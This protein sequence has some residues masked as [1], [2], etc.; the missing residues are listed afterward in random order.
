MT[1]SE[2]I[3]GEERGWLGLSRSVGGTRTTHP[4]TPS[5]QSRY[6]GRWGG[7]GCVLAI[8]VGLFSVGQAPAV[9]TLL[10]Q[11]PAP[12]LTFDDDAGTLQMFNVFGDNTGFDIIDPTAGKSPFHIDPAALDNSLFIRNTGAVGFGTASPLANIHIS[13]STA[14]PTLR[15]QATTIPGART[16]E[17]GVKAGRF[18]LVDVTGGNATPFAVGAATPTNTLFLSNTGQIGM[19]TAAPDSNSRLDIRSTLT[20]GILLKNSAATG[21][22]LR[23]ENSAAA[24][25]CGVQGNGDAQFGMVT[26]G[27]GLFFTAGNAGRME[28]NASGQISFG[29]TPPTITTDALIHTSGAKL[30]IGGVWTSVSSRAA[31]QDIETITSE[32][33]RD[34]VLALQPVG[35]RYKNELD[36]RYL[37]FIAED[38]PE[39]V[40]TRDR[41]GLAPMDIT[42]VLTKVVQDQDRLLEDQKRVLL[43]QGR[44][45]AEERQRIDKERLR[46]DKLE[47]SVASLMQRLTELE[48]QRKGDSVPAK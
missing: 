47:Q 25:R 29:L 37:G 36:E 17:W 1:T 14:F 41:K 8:F 12:A 9:E 4:V 39:L 28:L 30:T 21:H 24:F 5:K 44:Q 3:G 34:T 2:R 31:K 35:Y 18:D 26:P 13:S 10:L 20:N 38:V 15:M 27:K 40:A 7:V 32:E 11:G 45:L 23:I 6:P 22:F 33:A 19:G 43:D 16:W 42:A 48:Q 46:N